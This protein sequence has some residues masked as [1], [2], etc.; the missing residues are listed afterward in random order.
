MRQ[1]ISVTL[2]CPGPTFTSFLAEA[3]TDKDGE[4]SRKCIFIF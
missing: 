2:L 1:N 4:V 3:F